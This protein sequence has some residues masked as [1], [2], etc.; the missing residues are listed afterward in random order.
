VNAQTLLAPFSSSLYSAATKAKKEGEGVIHFES[1]G[2]GI[3]DMPEL[4]K[5]QSRNKNRR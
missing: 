1:T 4:F 2:G 5:N 3:Q